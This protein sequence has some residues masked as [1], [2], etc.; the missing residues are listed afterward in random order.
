M[1]KFLW[2]A[3]VGLGL[4]A[5]ALPADAQTNVRVGWCTHMISSAAAPFAVS[6]K[7][8]WF[9]KIGRAHV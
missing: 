8:G 5:T 7:L 6:N 1:Q 4:L 3:S 2:S 9:G